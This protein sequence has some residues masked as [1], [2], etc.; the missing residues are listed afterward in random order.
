MK[1]KKVSLSFM[2]Y[3]RRI[4]IYPQDAGGL[5]EFA[6]DL[7]DSINIDYMGLRDLH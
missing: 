4:V 6:Y 5:I 1:L 2:N 7:P 3:E